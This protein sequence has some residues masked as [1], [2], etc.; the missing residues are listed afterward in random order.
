MELC[1]T[2]MAPKFGLHGSQKLKNGRALFLF[3]NSF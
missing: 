1:I 2:G 3:M